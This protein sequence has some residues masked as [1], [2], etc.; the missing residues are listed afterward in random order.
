MKI[1][2]LISVLTLLNLIL[3]LEA[4]SQN[5]FLTTGSDILS[6]GG[7]VSYSMGQIL[8]SDYSSN[9]GTESQ[10]LQQPYEIYFS[11]SME[12]LSL[13]DLI[14]NIFPNPVTNNLILKVENSDF[15]DIYFE[16]YNSKSELVKKSEWISNSE[17][18]IDFQEFP[19]SV[20]F[21]SII[22]NGISVKIFKII[23][24]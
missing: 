15:R 16:I 14:C 21:L 2:S 23:K 7:S 19:A 11:T 20:Y 17:T 9:Y 18:L 12:E 10:G 13:T 3:H 4:K 5:G 22:E 6:N 8:D 1:Y 24:T